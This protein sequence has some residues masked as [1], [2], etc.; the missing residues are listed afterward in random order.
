MAGGLFYRNGDI[1]VRYAAVEGHL[2]ENYV[3][4]VNG[5]EDI[6]RIEEVCDIC[7]DGD[8]V[9][10]VYETKEE[11]EKHLQESDW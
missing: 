8:L 1:M 11:A 9:L 6:E 2:G 3:A 7:F 4:E 5:D 10:G